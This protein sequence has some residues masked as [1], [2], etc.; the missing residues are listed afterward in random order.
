[1]DDVWWSIFADIVDGI[2]YIFGEVFA[3]LDNGFGDISYCIAATAGDG[4][5]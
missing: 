3:F 5:L 2:K 4:V 1:M